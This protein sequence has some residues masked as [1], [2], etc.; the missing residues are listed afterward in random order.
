MTFAPSWTP[1]PDRVAGANLNRLFDAAA[2]RHGL[3]FSGDPAADYETLHGW[4]VADPGAFWALVWD[5]V[6]VAGD[7]GDRLVEPGDRLREH[8]FLPDATLNVAEN[9][10]REPSDDLALI[11]RGEDG[12]AVDVTRAELHDLVARI[13]VL[14]RDA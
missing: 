4:S 9:L 3:A 2:E 1:D 7:R 5:V 13:Q 12:E 10:L 8:R 14:L 6:G 11:F